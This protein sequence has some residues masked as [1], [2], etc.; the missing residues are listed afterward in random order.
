MNEVE[1][2]RSGGGRVWGPEVARL[3]GRFPCPWKGGLSSPPPG[4]SAGVLGE[5]TPSP[6]LPPVARTESPSGATSGR[7]RLEAPW[8]GPRALFRWSLTRHGLRLC[9]QESFCLSMPL[10]SRTSAFSPL[11]FLFLLVLN[12][13]LAPSLS[14]PLS[15]PPPPTYRHTDTDTH[16]SHYKVTALSCD[17]A[18]TL[19]LVPWV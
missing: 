9:L 5:G 2:R 1:G 11:L 17:P 16:V 18:H 6:D 12:H 3:E 15:A 10:K 13:S 7:V 4:G 8:R 19:V 14:F